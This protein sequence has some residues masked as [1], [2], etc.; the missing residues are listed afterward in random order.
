MK[1]AILFSAL[2]QTASVFADDGLVAAGK[3]MDNM[4][5]PQ[6]SSNNQM[7]NQVVLTSARPE[8]DNGW[9]IF[10]DALYWHADVGNAD[11][12]TVGALKGSNLSIR[13]YN[14]DFKWDWGFKVGLGVNMDHDM[15]D[16]NISY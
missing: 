16:S 13:D 10:A 15:W 9:Y 8:S 3:K 6:S 7:M 4:S 1:K 14:M 12:A 2:A 5:K 11:W